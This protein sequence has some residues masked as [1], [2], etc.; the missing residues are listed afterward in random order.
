MPGQKILNFLLHS[1]IGINNPEISFLSQ[2]ATSA[3]RQQLHSGTYI[4][5]CIYIYKYVYACVYMYRF[6]QWLSGKKKNPPAKA[7]DAGLIPGLRRCPGKG[8]G[9]PLQYSC[10]GNPM[11]RSQVGYSPRDR[12]RVRHDLATKQQRVC[13][14][15]LIYLL[16]NTLS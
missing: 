10:L 5:V 14:Y 8:N 6:P 9:N 16:E 11:D 1:Y 2:E 12:K 13:V 3:F 15:F 7:E 4:Y